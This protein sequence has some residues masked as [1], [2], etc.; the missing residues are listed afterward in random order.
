M[1]K[2]ES[3]KKYIEQLSALPPRKRLEAFRAIEDPEVRRL[4]DEGLPGHLHAEMLGESAV[5]SLNRN[6]LAEQA[7]RQGKKPG[8]AA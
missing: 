7:R 1:P 3:A 4:V 5:E 6:A 2:A 8:K